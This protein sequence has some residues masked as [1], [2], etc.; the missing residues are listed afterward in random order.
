M[1]VAFTMTNDT[2]DDPTLEVR[3]PTLS[4]V[5]EILH[6]LSEPMARFLAAVKRADRAPGFEFVS[7]PEEIQELVLAL[8]RGIARSRRRPDSPAIR[9]LPSDERAGE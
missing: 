1:V 4:D 3:T 7:A 5:I 9:V 8:L 6:A 2:Y